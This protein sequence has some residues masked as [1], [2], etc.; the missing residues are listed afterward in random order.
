[1]W[2]TLVPPH[3]SL[4]Q[5]MSVAVPLILVTMASQ[6]APGVATIKASGYQLHVSTIMIFT[7]LMAIMLSPYG[8]YSKCIEAITDAICQRPD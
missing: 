1:V 7:G 3:L 2:P 5:S 4:A 8:V 6:N